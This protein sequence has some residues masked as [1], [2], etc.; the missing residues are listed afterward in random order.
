[1]GAGEYSSMERSRRMQRKG[2][3]RLAILRKRIAEWTTLDI[4]I[5][6]MSALALKV[7]LVFV[8]FVFCGVIAFFW[9]RWL[10][11]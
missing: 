1:M 5:I 10:Q 9:R 11:I 7:L 6:A 3:S 4:L 8:C 2:N